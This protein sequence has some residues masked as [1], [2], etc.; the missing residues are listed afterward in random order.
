MWYK[1]GDDAYN[2][3]KTIKKTVEV[4]SKMAQIRVRNRSELKYFL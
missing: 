2:L 1:E 4:A 3:V